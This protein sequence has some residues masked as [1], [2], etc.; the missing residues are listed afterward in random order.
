M[1]V[2][3]AMEARMDRIEDMARHV[4]RVGT[5]VSTDPGAGSVRVQIADADR[6]VSYDLP[7]MQRQTLQNKDYAM[8]DV[9]EQMLCLFMPFGM[10]QGFA[11]GSI[12]S[13]V[14]AT[15]VQD[16]DKRHVDFADGSWV[17]YDRKAHR[18][19]AHVEQG[20]LR[21]SVGKDAHVILEEGRLI[22]QSAKGEIDIDSGEFLNLR[23]KLQ[24][25]QWTDGGVVTF[26]YQPSEPKAPE[27]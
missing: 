18:L 4:F 26:P 19:Q 17:Q 10:E 25:R 12:F 11:L 22:I 13:Q 15:P 5:V 3:A 1:D 21:V 2:F 9:G 6:L 20:E 23:G 24:I 8:P 16:Q 14:D 27:K 7:V